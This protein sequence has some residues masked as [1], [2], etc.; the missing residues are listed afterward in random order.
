MRPKYVVTEK[1]KERGKND[2]KKRE[3]MQRRKGEGGGGEKESY[4]EGI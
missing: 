3:K 1:R 2:L 4:T